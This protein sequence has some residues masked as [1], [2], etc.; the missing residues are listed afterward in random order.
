LLDEV[1]RKTW[2][3][4]GFV[5]SDA[6]AVRSL[7]THGY[8]RDEDDAAI[9][10]VRAGVNMD[11][12]GG[13]YQQR[14]EK[15]VAAGKITP[16]R[17]DELVLPIL[18]A[19][20]RI[21]LFEN[22]YRD[23]ALVKKLSADP[24]IPAL[25][26]EAAQRSF[27][28]LRNTPKLLPLD[29]TGK[30]FQSMA[31]IGYLADDP[32]AQMTIWGAPTGDRSRVVSVLKG[33]QSAVGD[34]IKIEY[35]MGPKLRRESPSMFEMSQNLKQPQ[36]EVKEDADKAL[37]AAVDAAR[38][39]DVSV[40]VLGETSLMHGENASR[41]TLKLAGRQQE[42]LEAVVAL[43]KPVVLVLLNGRPLDITWADS[44]V[45]AILEVWA[46]GAEGGDA[47]ADVLFGKVSPSG[48]LPITWPRSTGQLPI[49]YSHTRTQ[50]PEGEPGYSSRYA[51]MP[52]TPLYPFG[53]GLSYTTF[54]FSNLKLDKS[55][56]KKGDKL[57]VTVDVENNGAVAG[58][59]VAQLYI[60]QRAGEASAP[61]R[62]LKGFERV[63]LKPGE[64]KTLTF[65]LG[66]DELRYWS[67]DARAWLLESEQFD[68]WL[69]EDSKA[70]LH[71]NFKVVD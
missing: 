48:K 66:P 65:T 68:L 37:A 58:D 20:V 22:P 42:L 9:K 34:K 28:L 33:L 49:Y 16:E 43:G 14:L 62:L 26:R 23:E 39:N 24:A 64:K 59:E 4:Q 44:H 6:M 56:I 51:D 55:E 21:G 2:G 18:E 15:L 50:M 17:I 52:S 47:V 7:I 13:I 67:A 31:V 32:T 57:T 27:V 29:P 70:T 36:P 63:S 35:A 19:K 46:P 60:H 40:L 41:S 54:A 3:F 71:A 11:M 30:S 1:L 25:A 10:A 8:A 12:A 61:V 69:G 53:Y 38:S 45:A 5:V